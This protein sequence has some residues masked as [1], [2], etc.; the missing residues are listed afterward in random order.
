MKKIIFLLLSVSIFVAAQSVFALTELCPDKDEYQ[1]VANF[2][3]QIETEDFLRAEITKPIEASK[4]ADIKKSITWTKPLIIDNNN[5][6]FDGINSYT[7][8]CDI[9]YK[10]DSNYNYP[11]IYNNYPAAIIVNKDNFTI[12]FN[13]YNLNFQ[14]PVT[15]NFMINSATYGISIYQGVKNLKI[16][17]TTPN[18]S[19]QQTH[20]G[21]ITN[22]TGYAIF[23]SGSTQSYNSYDVYSL[24][25]KNL[26]IDNL[27]ITQNINGIF[28][29]N[30]LNPSIT[31][32]NIIYNYSP[33]ILYGIYFSN[34]LDG[35]IDSCAINQNWSYS[36]VYGFFLQDTS[37]LTVQ[38]C[39]AN[40]NRSLKN[41]NSTGFWLGSSL[42][43]IV[44]SSA[45]VIQNC[46]ANRNLCANVENVSAIGFH[47]TNDSHH[48]TISNCISE[49]T[50]HTTSWA[51]APEPITAP[52]GIGFKLHSTNFNNI[53]G[54]FSAYHQT[55]GFYDSASISSSF[56]TANTAQLNLINYQVTVP[57][58]LAAPGPLATTPIYLNDVTAFTGSGPQ[59]T[60]LSVVVS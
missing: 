26:M 35:L 20:K 2:R 49:M 15:S 28:L 18:G 51:A 53:S 6:D 54:N 13:G 29:E 48:N 58:H 36:D 10:P 32:T 8:P 24:R 33:R 19:N 11:F 56:F 59:L 52:D 21:S 50:G 40:V 9:I 34:I 45:N 55:C 42:L 37:N 4:P 60:N 7:L 3:Q 44:D 25:I 27:F 47:I 16:I 12:D 1:D 31:N 22:F 5:K 30:A 57:N 39:K 17:S 38:N 14:A 43:S 46:I 23:G 41:G